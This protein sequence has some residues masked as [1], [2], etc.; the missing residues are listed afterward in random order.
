MSWFSMLAPSAPPVRI[1]Q[2]S[3]WVSVWGNFTTAVG[4]TSDGTLWTWGADYGQPAHF[5]LAD[6]LGIVRETIAPPPKTGPA[7]GIREIHEECG[8]FYPQKE[9]RPLLRLVATNATAGQGLCPSA[10]LNLK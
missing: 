6:A 10:N 7:S 5:E 9:P 2:R 4:L 1:G 8:A 3:D